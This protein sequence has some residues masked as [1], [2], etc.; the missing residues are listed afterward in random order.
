MEGDHFLWFRPLRILFDEGKPPSSGTVVSIDAAT[1][2]MLSIGILSKTDKGRVIFWPL[3]PTKPTFE[4]QFGGSEVI[5]HITLDPSLKMHVTWYENGDSKHHSE[6]WKAHEFSDAGLAIW[7]KLLIRW[8]LIDGQPRQHERELALPRTDEERRMR[9]FECWTKSLSIAK[10][11]AP[12]RNK[13]GDF[14]FCVFY[15]VADFAH[16]DHLTSDM[17]F[18]GGGIDKIVDGWPDDE[19]VQIR[20]MKTAIGDTELVVATACPPGALIPDV[21]MGF[22]RANNITASS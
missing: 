18:C 13:H 3:L 17:V 7:F 21:V 4:T 6:S 10:L 16:T 19:P 11:K 14:L 20:P 2:E 9:E 22:P 8:S 1:D 15:V 5:D 12:P